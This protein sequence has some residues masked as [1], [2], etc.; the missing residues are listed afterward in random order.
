MEEIWKEIKLYENYSISNIGNIRNNKTKR[1]RKFA[2]SNVG[3]H[4]TGIRPNGRQGKNINLYPHQE[5]AK[6]FIP[7]PEN[8]PTVNHING[9]KT[10]NNVSNLEW[11]TSKEQT[12]H[13][14]TNGLVKI[15]YGEDV[16]NSILTENDVRFI[17]DHREIRNKDLA[18]KYNVHPNTISDVRCGKKWKHIYIT[19]NPH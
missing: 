17:L 1:V 15:N 10:D 7:N 9:I 14:F 8:K 19:Y 5:V 6:A 11:A 3:Y 4:F 18:K 16:H 12:Q 2:T 13:A